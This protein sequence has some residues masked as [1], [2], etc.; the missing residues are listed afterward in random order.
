[1]EA[2]V[3]DIPASNFSLNKIGIGVVMNLNSQ[4]TTLT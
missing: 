4:K 1:M 3:V 2:N